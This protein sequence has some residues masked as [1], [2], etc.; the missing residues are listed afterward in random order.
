MWWMQENNQGLNL[1][2]ISSFQEAPPSKFKIMPFSQEYLSSAFPSV[3][4]SIAQLLMVKPVIP[5]ERE[6]QKAPTS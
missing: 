2:K 4:M 1:S 5:T 3:S 6:G